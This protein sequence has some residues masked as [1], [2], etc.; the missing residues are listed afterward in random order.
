MCDQAT[1]HRRIGTGVG[2]DVGEET[3]C[4]KTDSTREEGTIF[5]IK[6]CVSTELLC[7]A[8]MA[9]VQASKTG[10]CLLA[11]VERVSLASVAPDALGAL[12]ALGALLL[13]VVDPTTVG[14]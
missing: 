1:V 11:A 10:P 5:N 12:G 2:K 6:P 9:N 13:N 4:E 8:G 7:T 14:V 3:G